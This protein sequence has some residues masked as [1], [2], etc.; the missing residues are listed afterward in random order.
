MS[1][2]RSTSVARYSLIETTYVECLNTPAGHRGRLVRY[3]GTFFPWVTWA[4]LSPAAASAH[5]KLKEQPIRKPTYSPVHSASTS[6]DR[7]FTK[8]PSSYTIYLGKSWRRS[9]FFAICSPVTPG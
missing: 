3:I 9:T 7:D 5:S 2:I 8:S 6:K 1:L 4:G